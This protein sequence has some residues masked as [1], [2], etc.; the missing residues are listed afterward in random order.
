MLPTEK[1]LEQEL[2]MHCAPCA[3]SRKSW[4]RGIVL[5][6]Q[7][8]VCSLIVTGQREERAQV[9]E[10]LVSSLFMQMK[11]RA[12]VKERAKELDKKKKEERKRKKI[13]LMCIS[14]IS[15]H[16]NW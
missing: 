12:P 11:E 7:R 3:Y 9:C 10:P 14:L 1:A 4:D 2:T 8:C 13:S 5:D 16:A 6:Q 15:S